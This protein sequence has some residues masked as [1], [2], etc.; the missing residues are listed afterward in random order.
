VGEATWHSPTN[1]K[2]RHTGERRYPERLVRS[3][4]APGSRFAPGWRER[5]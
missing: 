2:L 3:P 4:V 1:N 5:V